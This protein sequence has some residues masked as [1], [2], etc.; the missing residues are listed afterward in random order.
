MYTT[1]V[2]A[3]STN[4]LITVS[5]FVHSSY[6]QPSVIAKIPGTSGKSSMHCYPVSLS[7]TV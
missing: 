2:N 1:V 5:K 3:A 6:S 7:S 4:S